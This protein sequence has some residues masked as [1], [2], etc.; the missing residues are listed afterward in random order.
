MGKEAP[1]FFPPGGINFVAYAFYL[2]CG[3]SFK[4]EIKWAGPGEE[5]GRVRLLSHGYAW[6]DPGTKEPS[7][8]IKCQRSGN[9]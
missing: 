7:S 1:S 6:K 2:W 8:W 9:R 4:G 3:F 5:R